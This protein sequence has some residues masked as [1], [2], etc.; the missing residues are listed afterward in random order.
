MFNWLTD[1]G[2]VEQLSSTAQPTNDKRLGQ[3]FY[4]D[5]VANQQFVAEVE[6]IER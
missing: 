6:A 2:N 5:Y 4:T 1:K 3:S